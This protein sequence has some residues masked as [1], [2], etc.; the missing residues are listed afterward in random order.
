M[1]ITLPG[2]SQVDVDETTTMVV[3]ENGAE[4]R[5]HLPQALS[6]LIEYWHDKPN[7]RSLLADYITEIQ[8][9]ENAI[10]QVILGR[11]LDYAGTA[12]LDVL[13][14]LVGESRDGISNADL[15]L[16]IK[17]RI[18][19]NSSYGHA[20]DVIAVLRLMTSK[21][22][23]FTR[24]GI[25]AFRIDFLEAVSDAEMRQIP[26]LVDASRA[27]GVGASISFITSDAFGARY[28]SVSVPTLNAHKGYGSISDAANSP[29]YGHAVLQ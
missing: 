13:A 1:L 10:H 14:S 27:G 21:R 11:T 17:A 28:G 18:R 25:A 22:F 24:Y 15:I 4:I 9:L 19:A 20:R 8:D 2:G 26:R 6:R 5:L 16:R 29:L 23:T 12:Q 3:D 7:F